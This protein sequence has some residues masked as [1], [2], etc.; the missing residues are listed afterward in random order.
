MFDF[1]N[2]DFE[3]EIEMV[4]KLE[5]Q[6]RGSDLIFLIEYI[7]RKKGEDGYKKVKNLLEQYEINLPDVEEINKMDWISVVLTTSF[8]LGSVKSFGWE[9]EDIIKMGKAAVSLNFTVK[10]FFKYFLSAEKTLKKA[11]NNWHQYFTFGK[12]EVIDYNEK[13]RNVKVRLKDFKRHKIIC[14]YFLGLFGQIIQVSTGSKQIQGEETKCVF[15]GSDYHEYLF[16]W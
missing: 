5:G 10:L 7:K 2:F 9:K 11:A 12:V 6:E 13:E 4:K 8:M 16:Q 3:K 15:E 1:K 14:Y